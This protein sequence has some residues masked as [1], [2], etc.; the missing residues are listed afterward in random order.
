MLEGPVQYRLAVTRR[1][2]DLVRRRDSCVDPVAFGVD[3]VELVRRVVLHLAA[4][5]GMDVPVQTAG[6]HRLAV[7]FRDLA[8]LLREHIDGFEQP[9]EGLATLGEGFLKVG[10]RLV[11]HRAQAGRHD[12]HAAAASVVDGKLLE[13]DALPTGSDEGIRDS[14]E[15]L[16]DAHP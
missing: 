11:A 1:A 5:Q 13:G 15:S 3:Q 14:D 7:F 2:D 10:Q 8:Q 9:S 12:E 16:V 6:F 4:D